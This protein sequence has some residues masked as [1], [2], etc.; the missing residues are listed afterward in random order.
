MTSFVRAR[1]ICVDNGWV[2]QTPVMMGGPMQTALLVPAAAAPAPG[3]AMHALSQSIQGAQKAG[4]HSAAR[5]QSAT[6]TGTPV[7][8]A[9]T[10][11]GFPTLAPATLLRQAPFAISEHVHLDIDSVKE[12]VRA[13][14]QLKEIDWCAASHYLSELQ[15]HHSPSLSVMALDHGY[16]AVMVDPRDLPQA[17]PPLAQEQV[18]AA[19]DDHWKQPAP[20]RRFP[21]WMRR[22]VFTADETLMTWIHEWLVDHTTWAED[23]DAQT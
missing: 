20:R 4:S 5:R 1:I 6:A 8:T 18:A 13:A 10:V 19:I 9:A 7:P 12:T 16:M 23:H 15:E 17:L 22:R 14:L 21:R 2:T 11:A 3:T